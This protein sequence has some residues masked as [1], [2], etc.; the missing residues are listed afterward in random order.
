MRRTNELKITVKRF[1]ANEVLWCKSRLQKN[2]IYAT[3]AAR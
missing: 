1:K 2:D 3:M